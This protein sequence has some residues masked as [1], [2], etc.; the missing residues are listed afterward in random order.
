MYICFGNQWK[1]HLQR[2]KLITKSLVFEAFVQNVAFLNSIR[3]KLLEKSRLIAFRLFSRVV[4]MLRAKN[5]S[6]NLQEVR[7]QVRILNARHFCS[8]EC[9]NKYKR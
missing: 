9:M 4:K 8:H 7:E 2:L 3:Q 5:A 1:R 6:S